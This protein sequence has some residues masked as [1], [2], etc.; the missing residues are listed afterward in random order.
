MTK[1]ERDAQA[2]E[3]LVELEAAVYQSERLVSYI[4]RAI[5]R[6]RHAVEETKP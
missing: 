5:E 4:V 6:L 2:V 3:D 1:N